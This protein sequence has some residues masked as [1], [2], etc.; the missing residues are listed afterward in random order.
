[1]CEEDL[2]TFDPKL[3]NDNLIKSLQTLK[4]FYTDLQLKEVGC[5]HA[6]Y[7]MDHLGWDIR[8]SV[9]VSPPNCSC[10][11]IVDI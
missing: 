1:M 8:C 6:M 4:Q 5:V 9:N 11:V 7:C 3:N 10:R 2:K